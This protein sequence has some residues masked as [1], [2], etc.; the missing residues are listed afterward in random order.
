VKNPGA[1][2]ALV[3]GLAQNEDDILRGI[4][5][6][7]WPEDVR[8]V[9]R[10]FCRMW[11]FKTPTLKK[12]KGYWITSARELK[13]TCGEFGS[14][15]LK[16]ARQRFEDYME[17]HHGAP[18]FDVKDIGSVIWYVQSTVGL[19]RTRQARREIPHHVR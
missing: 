1:A 19:M 8:P 17:T 7:E 6:A 12:K 14:D 9:V 15:A 16:E 4:D 5:L 3:R 11:G 10:A 2:A 18:P 13:A